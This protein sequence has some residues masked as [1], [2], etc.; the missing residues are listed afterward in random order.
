MNL[1]ARFGSIRELIIKINPKPFENNFIGPNN[2]HKL[3]GVTLFCLRN[4]NK[5][6]QIS[7]TC[8]KTE[9]LKAKQ[10]FVVQNPY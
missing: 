8:L 2:L 4:P 6:V 1:M 9:H 5:S 10:F 3:S 7:G